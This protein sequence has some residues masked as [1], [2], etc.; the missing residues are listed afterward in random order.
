M[1]EALDGGLLKA[2][3]ASLGRIVGLEFE[4]VGRLHRLL[5]TLDALH[6]RRQLHP[7][8]T[9]PSPQGGH[10]LG[11]FNPGPRCGLEGVAAR[12]VTRTG[13]WVSRSVGCLSYMLSPRWVEDA[14]KTCR[15]SN[16]FVRGTVRST[17]NCG[18][19]PYDGSRDT[20]VPAKTTLFIAK[21]LKRAE[22]RDAAP[23][24][25]QRSPQKPCKR[26]RHTTPPADAPTPT[27]ACRDRKRERRRSVA[28]FAT[29]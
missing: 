22:N 26:S 28:L 23:S 4:L 2:N 9:L 11:T 18:E 3:N 21:Q 25:A 20:V 24:V 19:E 12:V 1:Q 6:S 5:K 10:F 7:G 14:F 15:E 29:S 16:A 27:D 13:A 17:S 8:T